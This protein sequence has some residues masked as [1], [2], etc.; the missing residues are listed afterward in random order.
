MNILRKIG[1]VAAIAALPGLVTGPVT[2]NP[3]S[4]FGRAIPSRT[5]LAGPAVPKPH[6]IEAPRVPVQPGMTSSTPVTPALESA[7][8]SSENQLVAA[9]SPLPAGTGSVPQTVPDAAPDATFAA[10]LPRTV[11]LPGTG[12]GGPTLAPMTF[13]LETMPGSVVLDAK[14]PLMRGPY[15]RLS[16]DHVALP[17]GVGRPTGPLTAPKLTE[18]PAIPASIPADSSAGPAPVAVPAEAATSA[19]RSR[20][21][22]AAP[23]AAALPARMAPRAAAPIAPPAAPPAT[24]APQALAA[25]Q[26]QNFDFRP[27][28][29]TFPKDA[30]PPAFT[31]DDELILQLKIAGIDATDTVV[32]YGTR[33]AVYLPLGELAR[34]LDLA[35]R[36]SDDGNYANGWFLSEKRTLTINLREQKLITSAGERLLKPGD[37]QAFDGELFLR[38]DLFREIFPL[39]LKPNLRAQA[40]YLATR[41]PFPFEERMRREAERARLGARDAKPEQARWPRQETPWLAASVPLADVELRAVSDSPLG[42]RLEGDLRLGADLAFMT[43]Q[44]YFSATT[45]DGLVASLIQMGRRDGEGGLLGPLDAT[46]FQFGDVATASMPLGLR[47]QAGRGAFITNRPF[48]NAS[49][50]EQ[51][52]IRGILP[53]GY[54]VE[55]Y[56]NDILVGSVASATNDQYEFLEVPVDYGLNVFRLVF[57]GPQGQRREEVRRITVGDGRVAKGQLEYDVGI[58]QRGENLLQVRGPNFNPIE[59]FGS[60]QAAGRVSYG[61][62]AGLTAVT[63]LAYFQEPNGP[64]LGVATA[65][66][67][68]GIGALALRADAALGSDGSSA[69][70]AG[71]GGRLLGGA[72][73]LSHFEYGGGFRDEIRTNARDPLR[74]ATELE[75]NGNVRMFRQAIP[76]ATRARHIAFADG[77]SATDGI[78][79]TSF[80]L[81]GMVISNTLEYSRNVAP[82]GSSFTQ[83]IGN[84]DLATFRRSRVQMRASVGYS[85]LQGPEITNISGQLAY[86][87]DDRTLISGQ[88]FYSMQSGEFGFGVSAAREFDRFTLAIDGNYA[89]EQKSYSI[90]L[91]VGLSFGRDPLKRGLFMVPPG[92]ASSGAVAVRAFRDMDGNNRFSAGDEP[93]EGVDF[94]VFNETA[95]TDEHGMARLARLGN[96]SPVA[97]QVDP[98]TLPDILMAPASRGV[99]IV[100][101]AGRFHVMDFP[102]IALSEIEGTISFAGAGGSAAR[103]VSG[104]RLV[105]IDSKGEVAGSTRTERGGSYFFE[106]VKPGRFTLALDPEQAKRLGIC[107]VGTVTVT[108]AP[109]SDIY[110][111]DAVIRECT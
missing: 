66:L 79:R 24:P 59:G 40:I 15:D 34:I 68:T 65:G 7:P 92:L 71:I 69:L 106:Q 27:G 26:Q 36:V 76:I 10:P 98:S 103:G 57:Y 9:T 107:M 44:S 111:Q 64:D 8:T 74:R 29:Q 58:V 47:G 12:A 91:R 82:D 49:V 11:P 5:A 81:E 85:L 3:H 77:R 86:Q 43:A 25:Q 97:V 28:S 55:L 61:L 89:F 101:R 110:T 108:V 105:L 99:E 31:I 93:L 67:R 19:P 75:F 4:G 51:I 32:A 94:S 13:R 104:L 83:L 16:P 73:S 72:F 96:G 39:D 14:T 17:S 70:G 52:D 38:S 42:Q 1:V 95:T 109:T 37:A 100:P 63:S 35:I 54:E 48:Q 80:R 2:A 60:W 78:L 6:L 20:M 33:E 23:I 87:V 18:A 30:T 41:E 46:E 56:R 45:R 50:F 88:A 22:A 90:A 62:S 102:I 84:F 21:I 53:N